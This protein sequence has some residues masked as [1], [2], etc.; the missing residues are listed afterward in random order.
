MVARAVQSLKLNLRS[1]CDE[2]LDPHNGNYIDYEDRKAAFW[3]TRAGGRTLS[4]AV[5]QLAFGGALL[6]ENYAKTAKEIMRTIVDNQIV[7]NC[8]GYNYGRPYRTWRD[9][10]LD[11]GVSSLNLAIGLDV[12]RPRLSDED[13]Q[14]FGTYL[15]PLSITCSTPPPTPM[16]RSPIGTWLRSASSAW[17]CSAWC[18]TP[19]G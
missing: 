1:L 14:E 15:V 17:E 13:R 7:E 2:R 18:C 10:C 16:K 9:N 11:A 8:E 12:L 6:E 5:E 19:S 3:A 4:T